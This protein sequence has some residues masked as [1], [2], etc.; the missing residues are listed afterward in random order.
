MG[1]R[2]APE[3]NLSEV[4]NGMKPR[5]LRYNIWDPNTDLSANTSDWT[6]TAK[7]LEG[8]PQSALDDESVTKTINENP[9][10]FKIVTPIRVDV[11]EKYLTSHPNQGFV[12]SVCKGFREGF[13]PWAVV[14]SPGYPVTN[15]ESKPAP[16]DEEKANFLRAQ[17]D[18]EVAK[19][20]FSPPFKHD[21][22]PGMYC[23]P[24]YAVPKPRSENLRL[25][26]DQ[27]Y[28]KFSLNSMINHDKVTGFPLDN[29]AHFGAMMM[30]LEKKEPG[31]EKVVWKSDVAEAYR[32]LPM[33]PHW[34]VKQV[35][36]IDDDYHVDRCNAFGGC[37]AGGLFISFNSLV[38]W[39]AKEVKSIRYLSD[40]VDDSSGCSRR[41]D[42][43]IYQ[44]Y[45]RKFP[46]EQVILLNLWD[47]LGIPHKP[48][49]QLF[50]SPI[51]IIGISV[52]ANLLTLTLSN[53][54][55][56]ALI[57]E[58]QWWC[59]PGR[60][61]KLR[62]WYQM[63][64]W[65]NWALNVYPRIRPALNNFYPKLKGCRDST[66]LIWVNNNIRDDFT[67]A[68]GVLNRSSG[69]RLLRSLHWEASEATLT[70][71]CDACPEGMGFWYPSLNIGFY[72]QTPHHE[73]P[74]LIFYF[75]A[76]CVH[77]ALFDA[78]RRSIPGKSGRFLL[79]TDNSNTVD[80]FSSLRALPPYN[81]LL[82][83]AV[84]ILDMGD[85]DMRVLHVP[86]VDN[87]VADALSRADFERAINL[88]PGL[89]I[90]CFEP[91]SW[92]PTEQ[93]S[94]TFQPPRGTLGELAL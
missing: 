54:A 18:I 3:K 52:D 53:E 74:D 60:K 89:K 6:L 10:L 41:D 83:T 68:V 81:H 19:G 57:A 59:R 70:V 58:L 46:R 94:I 82:K 77:S 14:P 24:I 15:N 75:E 66:S 11:F 7:P 69:V 79:Y 42:L 32:I 8:P 43:A 13:W 62:R 27:S 29:M 37:G 86:G 93:G 35:N 31:V 21:L 22:L 12:K 17:R 26:T 20:R 67:W 63:G 47:E 80:I 23:M 28:G 91:W 34:Q 5:Y 44:P 64:G 1:K 38:A 30:D 25:V 9:D 85:N 55:R 87:A 40:Y 92:S 2:L 48:H 90:S 49:K 33:H 71:F 61:E 50:G 56:E 84:D 72:S 45:E 16:S 78:H 65:V 39:I 76:L 73:H 88:T 4:A 36:R 51:P